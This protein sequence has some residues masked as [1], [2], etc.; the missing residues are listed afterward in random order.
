M[1][2]SP[3]QYSIPRQHYLKILKVLKIL[4]STTFTT[5]KT[6]TS[7]VLA[8]VAAA[9]MTTAAPMQPRDTVSCTKKYEGDLHIVRLTGGCEYVHVQR[10]EAG[11]SACD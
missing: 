11:P 4:A 8:A 1:H 7:F 6:S 2:F 10:R 5:M 9:S 3:A